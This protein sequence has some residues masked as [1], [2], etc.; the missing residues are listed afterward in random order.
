LNCDTE[1]GGQGDRELMELHEV[2]AASDADWSTWKRIYLDSFPAAERMSEAYFGAVF[3]AKDP[4]KHV[5][6]IRMDG[7][8]IGIAYYE[9]IAIAQSAYLWYLAIDQTRR[10][11]GIGSMVY[12]ELCRSLSDRFDLMVFEVEIPEL[13]HEGPAARQTAQRRIDWYRSLGAKV[14][15]GVEYFQNVDTGAPPTRMFLMAHPFTSMEAT[16][17]Y[18][19][20]KLIFEDD[21]RQIGDLRLV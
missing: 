13:A 14:L 16:E 19:R 21:V 12:K 20:M 9:D 3:A 15:E 6:S 10:G 8:P 18:E 2:T 11:G 1:L 7:N 5:L 17:V 4:C